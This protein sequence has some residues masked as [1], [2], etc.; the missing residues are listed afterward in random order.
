MPVPHF[1][2]RHLEG[3]TS[4]CHGLSHPYQVVTT[5]GAQARHGSCATR[6]NTLANSDGGESPFRRT[7][8][9]RWKAAV[10]CAT[11]MRDPHCFLP[12]DLARPTLLFAEGPGE[13]P[14]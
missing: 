11:P 3:V 10:Q 14:K 7:H 1:A 6:C 12:R 8:G 13:T 5:P 2:I 9:G 4:C